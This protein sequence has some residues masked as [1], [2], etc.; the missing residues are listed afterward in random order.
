MIPPA[1]PKIARRQAFGNQFDVPGIGLLVVEAGSRFRLCLVVIHGNLPW[2]AP[3]HPQPE[4][5][6]QAPV[7]PGHIQAFQGNTGSAWRYSLGRTTTM[8][9]FSTCI[10]SGRA[11]VFWPL[12]NLVGP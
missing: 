4:L 11:P 3:R 6:S 7:S 2:R 9:P 5:A 12:T 10:T 1:E 8:S